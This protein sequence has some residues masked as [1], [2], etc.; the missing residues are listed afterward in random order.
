MSFVDMLPHRIGTRIKMICGDK[1]V[2]DCLELLCSAGYC[3]YAITVIGNIVGDGGFPP[4]LFIVPVVDIPRKCVVVRRN[5]YSMIVF[6][7]TNDMYCYRID[8]VEG[9]DVVSVCGEKDYG[10]VREL[11]HKSTSDMNIDTAETIIG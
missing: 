4:R 1:D 6:I 5:D 11:I 10:Y 7:G 8:S 3:E 2:V 9:I